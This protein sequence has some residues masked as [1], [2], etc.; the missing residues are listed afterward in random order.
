MFF[1]FVGDSPE[2]VRREVEPSINHYFRTDTQ[3]VRL[4]ESQQQDESY[5]Y[6]Q[7][8]QKRLEA[9]TY[10]TVE[11]DLAIYGSPQQCVSRATELFK[12]LNMGHLMCWFNPGGL[13]PH[14]QV[15]DSMKRFAK[16]VM[17]ALRDL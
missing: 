7:D 4:G 12:E 13:I 16:E 5:K 8:A 3:M 14:R 9:I 17:P 1:F 10:D 11:R 15:L 6:L 2:Q